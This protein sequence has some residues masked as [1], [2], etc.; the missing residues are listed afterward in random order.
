MTNNRKNFQY[1]VP[2]TSKVDFSSQME[3]DAVNSE[4]SVDN[5]NNLDIQTEKPN[6]NNVVVE[7]TDNKSNAFNEFDTFADRE[8]S[9]SSNEEQIDNSSKGETK[10]EQVANFRN[11]HKAP[12]L[13]TISLEETQGFVKQILESRLKYNLLTQDVELDEKS[14]RRHQN[15]TLNVENRVLVECEKDYQVKFQK[16][17]AFKN[18]LM[19]ALS[20]NTYHPVEKY[21]KDE[22][23]SVSPVDIDNLAERYLG[24]KNQLANLLIKKTLIAAVARV[25]NPGCSVHAILILYSPQ[26]GIGK[27]SFL[28]T[29]AKTLRGS[30]TLFQKLT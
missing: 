15:E 30:M 27:S 22:L 8:F 23:D 3:V 13:T 1:P 2:K 14:L 25:L 19:D 12:E 24:N 26:Q 5:S 20:R 9:E 18:H 10:L 16:E 11:Q 17:K 7:Q 4:T 6:I 21:L 29:L 28:R